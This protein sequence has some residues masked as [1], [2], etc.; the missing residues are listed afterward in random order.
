MNL[1]SLF[2]N[3]SKYKLMKI[4]IIIKNKKFYFINFYK[5]IHVIS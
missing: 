2:D 5:M 3:Y 4:N 1:Y